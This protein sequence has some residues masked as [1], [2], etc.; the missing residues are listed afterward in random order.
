MDS[1]TKKSENEP[2]FSLYR[3]FGK[4]MG[5]EIKPDMVH[6]ITSSK[7]T[8]KKMMN[9]IREISEDNG[10]KSRF[11]FGEKSAD[12]G[13]SPEHRNRLNVIVTRGTDG[14]SRITEMTIG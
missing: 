12:I 13:E 14:R 3:L 7:N 4:Y 6:P 1:H 11:L 5:Q 9:E 2:K 10:L 8:I